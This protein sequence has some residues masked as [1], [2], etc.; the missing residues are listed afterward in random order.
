MGRAIVSIRRMLIVVSLLVVI[1]AITIATEMAIEG[2]MNQ[3][4]N[5]ER[6][7]RHA[8]G[9]IGI[10]MVA[11]SIA[12]YVLKKHLRVM[13]GM[14]KDWLDV[15]QI[16]ATMGLVFVAFHTGA[17]F[18]AVTPMIS[19]IFFVI[20]MISGFTG[21]FV[22]ISARETIR[23]KRHLPDSAH[24]GSE[25]DEDAISVEAAMTERLAKWRFLHRALS[26]I[27]VVFLISH[28]VS[29]LYF[30]G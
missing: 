8:F 3:P 23:K 13:P 19:F 26:V 28:V 10:L 4:R 21:L 25:E 30:G 9:V 1:M 11:I 14:Q 17:T 12:G 7:L 15:H 2:F 6:M 5:F 29:A 22:F 24:G 16:L 27:L 20:C 18:K